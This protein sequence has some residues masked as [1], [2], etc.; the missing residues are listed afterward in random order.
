MQSFPEWLRSAQEPAQAD[1]LATLIAQAGAGPRDDLE[2]MLS[3]PFE[4]LDDVLKG[5]VASG[6]VEVVKIGW[7]TRYRV[8]CLDSKA[9]IEEP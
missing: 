5:L 1:R 7:Q 8:P 6:Q 9:I 3:V 4:M 2:K